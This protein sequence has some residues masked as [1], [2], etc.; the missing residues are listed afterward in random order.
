MKDKCTVK[1]C[2]NKRISDDMLFCSECRDEWEIFCAE[3]DVGLDSMINGKLKE[4]Q[5]GTR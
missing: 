2:F 1:G 5:E 3:N 4:F